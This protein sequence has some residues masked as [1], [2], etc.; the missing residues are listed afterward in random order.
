MKY[1][2]RVLRHAVVGRRSEGC[3]AAARRCRRCAC[4]GS[5]AP[6]WSP[7]V[8]CGIRATRLVGDDLA[9]RR[10]VAEVGDRHERDRRTGRGCVLMPLSEVM[11][12][13]PS[14]WSPRSQ[15]RRLMLD[16]GLDD[17]LARSC[18]RSSAGRRA[19]STRR[20]HAA[21]APCTVAPV[22]R[23]AQ[24]L[25]DAVARATRRSSPPAARSRPRRTAS[26]SPS[27]NTST[28]TSFGTRPGAS[29]SGGLSL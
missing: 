6:A 17:P 8:I 28:S 11:T 21:R 7:N 20:R 15:M 5:E 2:L 19:R 10:V 22:A 18:C 4:R 1:E 24:D 14:P 27:G 29:S 13:W 3:V 9:V 25:V 12:T 26:R 16:A 23:D